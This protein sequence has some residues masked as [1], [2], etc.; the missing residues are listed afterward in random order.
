[1]ACISHFAF[2]LMFRSHCDLLLQ[3]FDNIRPVFPASLAFFQQ[4]VR[5][6]I[7]LLR[8]TFHG[9]SILL[10]R[11]KLRPIRYLNSFVHRQCS[12]VVLPHHQLKR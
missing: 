9:Q 2:E 3:F 11:L 1:M 5:I 7:S 12:L 8:V 6:L 10:M 4:L